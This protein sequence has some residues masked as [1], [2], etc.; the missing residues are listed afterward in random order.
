MIN[1]QHMWNYGIMGLWAAG[2]WDI[3]WRSSISKFYFP[4]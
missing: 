1:F 4:L 2:E 3:K